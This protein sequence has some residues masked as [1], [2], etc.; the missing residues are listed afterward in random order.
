MCVDLCVCVHA[1]MCITCTCVHM[2]Q[3]QEVVS[4]HCKLVLGA[5]RGSSAK[6]IK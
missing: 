6:S 5:E 2:L 4:S 1:Y 3:L